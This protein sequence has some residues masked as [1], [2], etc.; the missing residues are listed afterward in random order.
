MIRWSQ[1]KFNYWLHEMIFE[2]SDLQWHLSPDRYSRQSIL[3]LIEFAIMF[4]RRYYFNIAL[5]AN[6]IISAFIH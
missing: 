2:I 6:E 3:L 1:L 5:A 4:I